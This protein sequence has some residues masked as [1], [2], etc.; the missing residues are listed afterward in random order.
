MARTSKAA[1]R[2]V[3]ELRQS[4]SIQAGPSAASQTVC[5][6]RIAAATRSF[7]AD[8]L[9]G[10][11]A[12]KYPG[13]WND[14]GEFV[15]YTACHLSLAVLETAAHLPAGGLPLNRYVVAIHVPADVWASAQTLDPDLLDPSWSAIPAALTS[16][17]AGSAWYRSKRSLL[18]KVPSAIVPEEQAVLIHANHPDI[19]RL[20][21][22]I[23]RPFE[24]GRVLRA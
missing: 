1:Q 6:W 5:L 12:A 2:P 15:V 7:A 4:S 14:E 9:S 13:R 8:D 23:R 18:L 21:A 22:E 3:G 11:G 17:R 20:R 19:A 10:G 24:Y 16:V